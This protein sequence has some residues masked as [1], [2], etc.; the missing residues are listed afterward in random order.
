MLSPSLT[1]ALLVVST[2]LVAI[3]VLVWAFLRGWFDADAIAQQAT[4]I[5]E[6]GDLEAARPWESETQHAERLRL[7]A[8]PGGEPGAPAGE[9]AGGAR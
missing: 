1:L 2:G 6:H 3:A 4:V 8:A 5:F 9:V 7:Y